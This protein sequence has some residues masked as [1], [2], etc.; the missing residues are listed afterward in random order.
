RSR[1]VGVVIADVDTDTNVEDAG[2]LC[3]F[4]LRRCALL[5]RERRLV[6]DTRGS[7][8]EMSEAQA[9]GSQA[10]REER[11]PL[12]FRECVAAD[13]DFQRER[14]RGRPTARKSADDALEGSVAAPLIVGLARRAIEAE[15]YMG[16]GL[17]SLDQERP[18]TVEMPPVGDKA[19]CQGQVAYGCEQAAEPWVKRRLAAGEHD[20]FDG[21]QAAGAPGRASEEV[22]GKKVRRVVV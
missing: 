5:E 22:D 9:R 10:S 18:H 3:N 16:H 11:E 6:G 4:T 2:E 20:M 17:P 13:P 1:E 21:H 19:A 7:R 15:R 12:Q 8:H 14:K